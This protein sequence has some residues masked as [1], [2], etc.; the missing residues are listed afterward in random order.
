M[1]KPVRAR[2]HR[3]ARASRFV[4]LFRTTPP[5]TVCPNFYVLAHASGCSFAPQCRYCYLKSSFWRLQ[6]PEVFTNVEEML[7]DVERW[8]EKDHLETYILNAGNLSDS[9]VFEEDRPIVAR[10]VDVF[11]NHAAG[12]PHTLLLTTKGGMR[13]CRSLFETEP[14]ARV[15]VS[16][17]VNSTEAAREF[18]AG[19]PAPKERFEAAR[20]L[21]KQGWRVRLRIDPMIMGFD[22]S[23]VVREAR[24]LKPERITVGSLRAE[25]SL[26]KYTEPGL[27]D[28]LE[29]RGQDGE[30]RRYPRNVR[31]E[32]YRSVVEPL[33]GLAPIGLCEETPDVWD[34]LGLDRV[35][36]CCNCGG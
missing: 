22:Y 26:T 12:R 30:L 35:G 21:R 8:I 23:E 9:L 20:A 5:E 33:R 29:P 7:A 32:M 3:R 31:M 10:L 34:E 28:A 14:C 24:K 1:K 36:K 13:E 19:V 11:R 16:F 6:K 17:S 2:V 27:F 15:I 4:E 25:K 18:E